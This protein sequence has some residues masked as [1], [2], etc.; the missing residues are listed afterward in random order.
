MN[1]FVTSAEGFI[2]G[3]FVQQVVSQ[4]RYIYV[5]VRESSRER[6]NS[7]LTKIPSWASLQVIP[8][9]GDIAAPN[10]GLSANDLGL[11]K[12]NVDHFFHFT[13]VY[14]IDLDKASQVTRSILGTTNAIKVAQLIQAH[15]FHH[16]S[17]LAGSQLFSGNRLEIAYS[18]CRLHLHTDQESE[19]VVQLHCKIPYQIYG[20]AAV[21]G[22]SRSKDIDTIT[23]TCYTTKTIH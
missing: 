10:M 11:L 2:K 5:L 23:E 7:L 16:V 13:T 21:S 22:A 18:P 17:P 15:C 8:V 12:G 9:Y 20:P 1:Y 3:F 14:D 6:I 19:K 4:Q